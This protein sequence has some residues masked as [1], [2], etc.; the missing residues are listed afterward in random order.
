MKV[1]HD[2]R[3]P[4]CE[5]V[6]RDQRV[7]TSR[8]PRCPECHEQMTWLPS[9]FRTD[10]WGRERY[11]VATDSYHRSQREQDRYAAEKFGFEPR[12]DKVGGARIAREKSLG[13]ASSYPGQRVRRTFAPTRGIEDS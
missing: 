10:V 9:G 6:L 12:G 1:I 2:I 4:F 3:C 8:F 7:E 11:C 13:S 5:L